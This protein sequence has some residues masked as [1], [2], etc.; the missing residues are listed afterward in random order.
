METIWGASGTIASILTT[1]SSNFSSIMTSV[2]EA[3]NAIKIAIQNAISASNKN[4]SD[5]ISKIDR[6][7][8]QQTARPTTS[9][10]PSTSINT[11]TNNNGGDGVPRIGDKVT[12]V[13]DRYYA[14]SSGAN[15]SGYQMLG[16]SVYITSINN[17]SWAKKPYHISR[18]PTLGSGDLG[19]V[20]LDQLQGYRTGKPIIDKNQLAWT[21][22]NGEIGRASCRER[23]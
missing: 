4:A 13:K 23:V 22:E 21:Q 2:Q 9:N 10:T 11:N 7:Q 6:D 16:Q 8:A 5:N 17:A 19:W 20:T 15:P 12:Y 1:Y 18:G 3:I 14:S